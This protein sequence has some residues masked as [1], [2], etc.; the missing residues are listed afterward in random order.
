LSYAW[1]GT[2]T[3]GIFVY[4]GHTGFNITGNT[5]QGLRNNILVDGRDTGSI[6]N[7]TIDNSKSGIS[8]QYTDAG[9]GNTEGYTIDIS[10]NKEGQFGN[11]WGVNMHLNGHD[12]GTGNLV[13]N[14][15]KIAAVAPTDVQDALKANSAANNGWTV[16]DQGYSTSN[17]TAVTVASTGSDSNQGSQLSPLATIQTGVD[18][19]VTGGTVNV[20]AGNYTGNVTINRPVV[21]KG[22]NADIDPTTGTARG[23]E[24][25]ITGQVNVYAGDTLVSGFTITNPSWSG[26]TI[27]G[28]HVWSDGPVISNITLKNNIFTDINNGNVKGAYGVMVQGEVDNVSVTGNLFDGITSMGWAHAV[29]VTPTSNDTV[30]PTAVSITGNAFHNITNDGGD[31]Q[32]AFSL[33]LSDSPGPTVYADASQ[34]TFNH[35]IID[36]VPVRN[37]DTSH[38]LDASHNW[39]GTTDGSSIA[40]LVS[41]DVTYSPWYTSMDM[42]TTDDG[43]TVTTTTSS[44]TTLSGNSNAS[45]GTVQVT[46]TI[47]AGTVIS[48]DSGWDGIINPPTATSVTLNGYDVFVAVELGSPDFDLT[49]SQPARIVLP[50]QAGKH[51]GFFNHAG[52]FTEINNSCS[53]DDV[54]TSLPASGVCKLQISGDVVIWTT[55]FSVYVSYQSG[56]STS[57]TSGG[58]GGG[59]GGGGPVVA[60]PNNGGAAPTTPTNTNTGTTGTVNSGGQVLGAA[61]YNFTTDLTIGSRGADVDALQQV[62]IDEGFLAIEAPTGYFGALTKAAVVKYQTAH[63]ITPQSGYVGPKTR[64]VLNAGTTPT[65]SDEQRS[66][67]IAELEAKLEALLAQIRVLLGAQQ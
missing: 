59:G 44:E 28:A 24:A 64:T 23:S 21:L 33:D 34:A 54:S 66:L 12:D 1:G 32:Y 19:V 9:T 48:A 38:T 40:L 26:A 29:E 60:L 50:G 18:A 3:R 7:N 36:G 55:H 16:Q 49:L 56:G 14:S 51:V 67:L 15:V 6:T 4:T 10:G 57:S 39:W 62:L 63:G 45:A 20:Q 52:D 53:S 5:I 58:G 47:A 61:T 8:V 35:N 22:P 46:A 17:R 42:T 43:T 65:M 31:D 11:E 2:I 30:V 37:L 41:G 25:T 13:G 27:K